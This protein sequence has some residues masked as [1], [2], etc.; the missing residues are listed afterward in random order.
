[1]FPHVQ[2]HNQPADYH[3]QHANQD[4][5][6]GKEEVFEIG[7]IRIPLA[8]TEWLEDINKE[9]SENCREQYQPDDIASFVQI[10]RNLIIHGLVRYQSNIGKGIF[11]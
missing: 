5:Q 3:H 8:R 10:S 9:Q 6:A 2:Q 4:Y 1:M 7:N 11:F